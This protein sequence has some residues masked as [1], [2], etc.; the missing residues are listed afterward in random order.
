MCVQGG[1]GCRYW[2][3]TSHQTTCGAPPTL[4]LLQRAESSMQGGF[5]RLEYVCAGWARMSL[6]VLYFSPDHLR[7][8]TNFEAV[9]N[10]LIC[11]PVT[12]ILVFTKVCVLSCAHPRLFDTAELVFNALSHQRKMSKVLILWI[13]P[14]LHRVVQVSHLEKFAFMSCVLEAAAH[15]TLLQPL[16]RIVIHSPQSDNSNPLSCVSPPH[17]YC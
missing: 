13:Q 6:L 15:H 8:P 12:Q 10:K 16:L 4:I 9:S 7:N 1:P 5:L 3:F 2:S 11:S 17:L 14:F